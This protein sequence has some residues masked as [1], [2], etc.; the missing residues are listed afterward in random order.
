VNSD[1]DWGSQGSKYV[2]LSGPNAVAY[3]VWVSVHEIGHSLGLGHTGNNNSADSHNPY[4]NPWDPMSARTNGFTYTNPLG[5]PEGPE[6]TSGN[7]DLL[8]ALPASRTS[9]V[10]LG[11]VSQTVIMSALNRPATPHFLQIQL[12]IN[13]SDDPDA[14]MTLE[15]R[16]PSG[17]DRAIPRPTVLVHYVKDGR[18]RL[19]M[20]DPA[21]FSRWSSAERLVGESY[22]HPDWGTMRVTSID[23]AQHRA[24]IELTPPQ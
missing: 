22:S 6:Y 11:G 14:H 16:E 2:T 21:G 19:Q 23:P 5:R 8:G 3:D 7:R 1:T 13:S 20:D 10:P 9:F 18:V 4:A 24:E 17:F 12:K 15:Y